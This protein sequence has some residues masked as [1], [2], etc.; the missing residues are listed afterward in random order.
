[1]SDIPES[2][3]LIDK[4]IGITSF[5]VIRRLRKKVG[6]RKMGHAGTLDP[7]ASGLLIVG[8]GSEGTKQLENFLKLDKTYQVVAELGVRT[9]TGDQEG[10]VVE[11]IDVVESFSAEDIQKV[12]DQLTGVTDLPVPIYSAVK[13]GGEPLYKKA[14]RG[15]KVDPPVR[16]MKVY[17][18]KLN[19]VFKNE[20]ST[21]LDLTMDVA[22]GVFVR[23]VVEAIGR[24][25]DVPATTTKLRRTRIGEFRVE[26]A[27]KI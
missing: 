27:E 14:R 18:L 11:K 23:S 13:V 9:D 15:E 1:M 3:Y 5:D 12:C 21:F 24:G 22:S 19:T 4:P 20:G 2:I 6:I 10:E 8:V 7:M 25:L 17:S 16:A 26:D